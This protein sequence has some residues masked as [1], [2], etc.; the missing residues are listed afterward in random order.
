[1]IIVTNLAHTQASKSIE[2]FFSY[3]N[4][5]KDELLRNELV[6]HL[7]TLEK[8]GVITSWYESKISAGTETDDEIKKHLNSARIILLLITP[9]FIASKKLWER[10]VEQAMQRCKAKEAYVIPVLLRKCH[11]QG[12]PLNNYLQTLP[13][14]ERYI[15]SLTNQDEGFTEVVEGIIDVV[16]E[17][18]GLIE[19]APKSSP[20]P[21][22]PQE[23]SQT[24]KITRLLKSISWYGVRNVFLSS[25]WISFLVIVVRF[26]GL[27]EPSELWLFDNMMRFKRSEEPDKNILII[28]VTPEDIRVQETEPRQGSLTDKTLFKILT[29]LGKMQPKVIGLD[30]H[31]D[32]ETNKTTELSKLL[33][34]NKNN[35]IVGV[36]YVGDKTQQNS[37]GVE[38]PPELI[39]KR[40]GFSDF[41]IDKDSIVRRHLLRMPKDRNSSFCRSKSDNEPITNAFSL[42]LALHFLKRSEEEVFNQENVLQIDKTL[43]ESIYADYRGGY[44]MFTDLNGYQILLNYR[45]SCINGDTCSPENFATKVTVADVLNPDFLIRYKEFVKDKIVLIGVTDST[46]EAPWTT[47]LYSE[48][49]RQ[50]P[51]VVI[52]GQMVS[53]LISAVLDNRSLLQVWSIWLEMSWIFA[54]SLIGGTL[55]QSYRTNRR[56]TVLGVIVFFSLP[57]SCYIMFIFT[58]IW[59]PCIPP[60]LSFLGTGGM[61][62]LLKLKFPKPQKSS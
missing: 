2:V 54:W 11:W 13:K 20:L 28:Q 36:C 8:D 34:D 10:D 56:L 33:K 29:I 5:E 1:V 7:S 35:P 45:I 12:K 18:S 57:F 46:Y 24:A 26:L 49:H 4:S 58:L 3:A 62:L 17:I 14:N 32:F 43:F 9:D 61:V 16:N 48:S 44:S 25:M 50:I 15:T 53:Q 42:K 55:F 6:K 38:P 52:Q 21:K 31:R 60:V 30:I 19:E 27:I 59:I 47:P 41:L 51:G 22:N 23:Q 40:L 39:N 37:H